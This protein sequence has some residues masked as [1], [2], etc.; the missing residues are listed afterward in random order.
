M[1]KWIGVPDNIRVVVR[2]LHPDAPRLRFNP[3]RPDYTVMAP[4]SA[5]AAINRR[6]KRPWRVRVAE[7]EG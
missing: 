6:Y 3:P 4:P 2:S 5:F 7:P 1:S